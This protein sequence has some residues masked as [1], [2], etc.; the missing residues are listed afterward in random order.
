MRGMGFHTSHNNIRGVSNVEKNNISD[1]CNVNTSFLSSGCGHS[2]TNTKLISNLKYSL[3]ADNLGDVSYIEIFS[4][5]KGNF[6]YNVKQIQLR[7]KGLNAN[8]I[9]KV[10]ENKIYCSN[11]GSNGE[12]QKGRIVVLKNGDIINTIKIKDKYGA[13]DIIFDPGKKKAYVMF[14]LQP[15]PYNPSG[16]PFKIIDTEKDEV[17][18][19]FSLKGSFYGYD[20]KGNYIYVCVDAI[21]LGYKDV[22]NNYIASIKRNTQE[23]KVLTPKGLNFCPTD[24]KIAPNGKIYMVSSFNNLKYEGCKEPKVSIYNTD[25]TFLKEIKLDLPDCNKIVINK[26]GMAYITHN[27]GG[28]SGDTI[29]VF[30]TNT[31]KVVGKIKGFSGPAGMAIKDNYLFV[32]NYNTGKISVVDLKLSKIIG[33]IKLGEGVNPSTLVVF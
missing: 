29:T 3:Y 6:K 5:D 17:I 8:H 11:Y 22:P 23:I 20:I 14:I 16:T 2:E 32:S 31:D 18:K 26:D 4:L 33:N 1:S 15:A 24:L 28:D 10:S 13:Q 7:K 19:P 9:Y 21:D 30:N 27:N 25:G 12:I